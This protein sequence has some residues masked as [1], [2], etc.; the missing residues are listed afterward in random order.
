[1]AVSEREDRW[2]REDL[3][4]ACLAEPREEASVAWD[5]LYGLLERAEA[6]DDAALLAPLRVATAA[7][8]RL[9]RLPAEDECDW[10]TSPVTGDEVADVE[11]RLEELVAM[12]EWAQVGGAAALLATVREQLRHAGELLAAR[13]T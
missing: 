12:P 6:A 10:R 8:E 4:G 7:M 3:V 9:L 11:R 13:R 1:M 5:L 2:R